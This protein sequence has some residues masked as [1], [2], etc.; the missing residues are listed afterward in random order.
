MVV[1]FVD[2]VVKNVFAFGELRTAQLTFN[3]FGNYQHI[4]LHPACRAIVQLA[5]LSGLFSYGKPH[6][7]SFCDFQK[8]FLR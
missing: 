6:E 3:H 8:W 7:F 4:V 2:C 5:C 1:L